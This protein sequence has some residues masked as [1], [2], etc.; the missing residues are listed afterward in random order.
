MEHKEEEEEKGEEEEEKEEK[1]KRRHRRGNIYLSKKITP[2]T[3][4]LT[5]VYLLSFRLGL[6]CVC[7]ITDC[8]SISIETKE[9]VT[10]TN[11][12]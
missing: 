8:D 9:M 4:L 11:T 2:R 10:V 12:S 7:H 5:F 1:R 6:C 3:L